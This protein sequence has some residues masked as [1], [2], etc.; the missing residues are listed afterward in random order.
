[1]KKEV[2][3]MPINEVWLR[4][5]LEELSNKYNETSEYKPEDNNLKGNSNEIQKRTLPE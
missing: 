1:M 5:A 3:V 4:T 2:E